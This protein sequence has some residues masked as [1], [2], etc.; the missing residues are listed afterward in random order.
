MVKVYDG[1]A[2]GDCIL[3]FADQDCVPCKKMEPILESLSETF[4]RVDCEQNRVLASA[5]HASA[6]TLIRFSG[7]SPVKFLVGKNNKWQI[8]DWL[9]VQHG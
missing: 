1:N 9:E 5:L 2:P 8:L 6:P 7:G 4:L 3:F